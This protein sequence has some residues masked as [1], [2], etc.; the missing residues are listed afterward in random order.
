MQH[1]TMVKKDTD[2][3]SRK[4]PR[5]IIRLPDGMR[6]ALQTVARKNHRTV[7]GEVVCRLEKSLAEEGI[8]I[9]VPDDFYK[10]PKV[11][12][13]PQAVATEPLVYRITPT[14]ELDAELDRLLAT[15]PPEKKQALVLLLSERKTR[16]TEDTSESG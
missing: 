9:A 16:A 15:L 4:A 14:P 5:I 13:P 7:T 6:D 8:S 12:P 10:S 11:L 3:P 2:Y 1:T